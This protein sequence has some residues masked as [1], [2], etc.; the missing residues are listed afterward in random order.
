MGQRD[1]KVHETTTCIHRK[2]KCPHCPHWGTYS[3]VT[4]GHLMVYEAF[5]LTCVAGCKRSISRREMKDHLA[6][7]CS[8]E[9]VECPHKMASCTS[10]VKRKDLKE[11]TYDKGHHLQALV[12][13]CTSA[14]PVACGII[15]HV[16]SPTL[17]KNNHRRVVLGTSAAAVQEMC[18][19]IQHSA[20]VTLEHNLHEMMETGAAAMQQLCG[21]IQCGFSTTIFSFPLAHRPWFQNTPSRYPRPP[22]VVKMDGFKKKVNSEWWFSDP[23]YSHFGGYKMCLRV[24][25]NG[26]GDVEGSHVSVFNLMKGANDDNLKWPFKGTIKVSLLNQLEDGQ[27]YMTQP[28]SPD[29]D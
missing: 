18:K 21:I 28:W 24:V 23:L 11:H 14:V 19:I 4:T 3:T 9:L 26:D 5:R 13:S 17:E 1:L 6:S 27:C 2:F 7:T 22:W 10:V 20:N 12:G 25:A 16:Y 8:E 29:D 15:K